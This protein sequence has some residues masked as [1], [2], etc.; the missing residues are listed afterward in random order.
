MANLE[1]LLADTRY[2]VDQGSDPSAPS[3]GNRVMYTKAGGLY[4]RSSSGIV[5]PIIDE[6][7]HDALDHSG[8]TGIPSSG[9]TGKRKAS[10]ES[11]SSTS[12]ADS[13]G[14]TFPVAAST[15]YGFVFYVYYFTNATTVGIRLAINGPA[16]ATGRFGVIMSTAA[17]GDNVNTGISQGTALD[18]AIL[19]TAAGP[20]A[21]PAVA[22]VSGSMDV[23]GTSGTLALRH[24]SE[25]ATATT[26][27]QGSWGYLITL[28]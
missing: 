5:G 26:I 21:S 6:T 20:G 17:A 16:G 27:E 23:A 13:T 24:A 10:S 7:L 11:F 22:I 18:T 3:A 19:S 14:L 4:L 15:R 28:V 8:L 12:F 2:W 1:T 25:T 9:I